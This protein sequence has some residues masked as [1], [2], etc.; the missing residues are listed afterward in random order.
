MYKKTLALLLSA[1][2]AAS[3]L[4]GCGKSAS[5]TSTG[6]KEIS[7]LVESGSPGESVAKSTAAEFEKQ[8]GYKVV[9]DAVPY[10]GMFDKLSTEISAKTSVHDVATL[11]V[12]W[13]PAFKNALLPLDDLATNDVKSDF[14]PTLVD[15]GT[16]NGSLYGFPMWINS[17]VL[18]YRTD[19]FNNAAN[20]SAFKQKYGYDLT[21]PTT[22]KQYED[23]ASFFTKDGMYG[24][25]VFGAANGDTV[26]SWLDAAAQAGANP[27]VLDK[28]NN[29]L[30]NQAPYVDALK[31]LCNIYKKG[32]APKETLSVASTEAE[33]MF[34]NGKLALQLNWS[35]QY[36][37]AYAALPGKV[38]VAPM[39]GGSAGVAATTGP[40]YESILKTTKNQDIAKKYVKF[41]YD[42]NEDYMQAPLKIAGRKSVYEKCS[43]QPG[44]EHLK[45][46]LD[47]LSAKQ[48]QNRPATPHW[49]QIEEVLY[50]AIQNALAGKATPQAA[51]DDAKTKIEAIVK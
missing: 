37:A 36:P 23:V 28:D 13:L 4:A 45:A 1:A 32:Y 7:V 30:V 47:T 11:D 29:V 51:L 20:K 26:C 15:G 48:S 40:W 22:W 38:G 43:S 10:S 33:Q 39:I 24:T 27:L 34:V 19:L 49:N 9:V 5:N 50:G 44:D 16:L 21:V 18:I 14:L 31:F 41:M 12:L 35:H 8:T 6:K 2:M 25:A 3:L 46:V 42:H 17:K